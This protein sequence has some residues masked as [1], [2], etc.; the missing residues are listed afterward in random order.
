MV[1]KCCFVL[2]IYTEEDRRFAGAPGAESVSGS[3]QEAVK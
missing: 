1:S 2:V 3:D